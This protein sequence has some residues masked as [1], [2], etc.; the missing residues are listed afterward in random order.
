MVVDGPAFDDS[1]ARKPV[2]EGGVPL[3]AAGGHVKT[4]NVTC[5]SVVTRGH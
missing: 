2:H 1:V 4:A 5:G 3:V